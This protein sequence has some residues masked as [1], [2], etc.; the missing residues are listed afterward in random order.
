MRLLSPSFSK[1]GAALPISW[2]TG[3]EIARNTVVANGS[4]LRAAIRDRQAPG[5]LCPPAPYI[6]WRALESAPTT[7]WVGSFHGPGGVIG[8]R[9]HFGSKSAR[10][11]EVAAILY[12]L[13]ESAKASG[14]DPISYLIEVATRAQQSPGSVLLP[15]DFGPRQ[16][17]AA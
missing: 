7:T 5:E 14:V 3:R 15:E 2:T 16:Q 1:A 17:A 6:F 13:V 8:R 11:T 4:G 12:S 9:N 10:G